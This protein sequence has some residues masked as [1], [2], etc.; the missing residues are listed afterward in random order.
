MRPLQGIILGFVV[1]V[2]DVVVA[3]NASA[4]AISGRVYDESDKPLMGVQVRA[5]AN[6]GTR[7]AEALTDSAGEYNLDITIEEPIDLIEYDRLGYFSGIEINI[8][9][10]EPG[11]INKV[12]YTNPDGPLAFRKAYATSLGLMAIFVLRGGAPPTDWLENLRNDDADQYELVR[13]NRA[14]LGEELERFKDQLTKLERLANEQSNAKAWSKRQFE[15]LMGSLRTARAMVL[16]I[17]AAP[18]L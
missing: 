13:R 2:L 12:L 1:A 16:D 18:Q 14:M 15:I 6:H 5:F 4:I 10:Q 7:V 9:H 17:R 8:H 11:V 3:G